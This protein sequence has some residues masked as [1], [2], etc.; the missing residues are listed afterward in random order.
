MRIR[1]PFVLLP[2]IVLAAAPAFACYTVYDSANYIVYRS[3][4]PP[5]DMSRP[6]HETLPARFPGGLLV[7]DTASECTPVNSL[8]MGNGGPTTTTASP[9]LTH[10]SATKSQRLPARPVE[11]G[12]AVVPPGA[13]MEPGVTVLPSRT[14]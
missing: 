9:L 5:V 13:T 2:F 4:Q 1:K 12:V 11:R 6:L 7:F 14:R 8:A 10:A 3:E